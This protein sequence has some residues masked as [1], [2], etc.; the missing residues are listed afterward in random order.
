MKRV[1]SRLPTSAIGPLADVSLGLQ[2]QPISQSSLA[3]PIYARPFRTC[4]PNLKSTKKADPGPKSEPQAPA[5]ANINDKNVNSEALL[6]I[7]GMKDWTVR[8][9]RQSNGMDGLE[10]GGKL[11]GYIDPTKGGRLKDRIVDRSLVDDFGVSDINELTEGQMA[12]YFAMQEE[13]PY[14]SFSFRKVDGRWVE[15]DDIDEQPEREE[16]EGRKKRK[17]KTK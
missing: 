4:A 14:E 11:M 7:M 5:D 3:T 10:A 1:R 2:V 6:K 17:K 8:V 15:D 12:E 16:K 13:G 9:V